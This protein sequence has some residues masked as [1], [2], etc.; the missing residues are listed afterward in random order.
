MS[1]SLDSAVEAG[2][3]RPPHEALPRRSRR[4][5]FA[6][7]DAA[8]PR[9]LVG[10]RPRP[11]P[12][13]RAPAPA[14]PPRPLAAAGRAHRTRTS[15]RRTRRCARR[16]EETA[17]RGA[18]PSA[19]SDRSSISTSIRVPTVTCISTSATCSSR[20]RTH[21]RSGRRDDR[22]RGRARRCAGRTPTGQRQ[23]ADPSLARAVGAL[24]RADAGDRP[25]LTSCSAT[26]PRGTSEG[27]Q[28]RR[29]LL[30]AAQQR[31]VDLDPADTLATPR[32]RAPAA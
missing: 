13:P 7:N 20:T 22:R 11:C 23:H 24:H 3:G 10:G 16:V 5:P 29:D 12:G 32:A 9:D 19:G 26:A 21:H 14:S 27:E 15:V 6:P 18:H 30:L 2:C 8:R 28:A 17:S 4:H 31:D 1:R 25:P